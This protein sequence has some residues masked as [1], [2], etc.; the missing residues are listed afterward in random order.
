[1]FE[2]ADV[3]DFAEESGAVDELQRF[4]CFRKSEDQPHPPAVLF[5]FH[6]QIAVVFPVQFPDKVKTVKGEDGEAEQD[7]PEKKCSDSQHG[8]RNLFYLFDA[9]GAGTMSMEDIL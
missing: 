8:A 4:F 3:A 1:M 5:P 2:I 7:R 9:A 6:F